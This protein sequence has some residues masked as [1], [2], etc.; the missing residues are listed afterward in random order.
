[1]GQFESLLWER[2][3]SR[4]GRGA[5]SHGSVDLGTS[6]LA[7]W[8]ARPVGR[9]GRPL[10]AEIEA[11]LEFFALAHASEAEASRR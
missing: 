8:T 6:P 3:V 4:A 2:R 5:K 9:L 7:E 11:Y 1:M 10:M